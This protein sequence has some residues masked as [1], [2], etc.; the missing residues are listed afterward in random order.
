MDCVTLILEI[1]SIGDSKD[2][3]KNKVRIFDFENNSTPFSIVTINDDFDS[4]YQKYLDLIGGVA[5][6]SIQ[7][8]GEPRQIM[9]EFGQQ[10][11]HTFFPHEIHTFYDNRRRSSEDEKKYLRLIIDTEDHKLMDLPWELLYDTL[12]DRHLC[13]SE[14]S[15]LVRYIPTNFS[16]PQMPDGPL[17]ILCMAANPDG[18][19]DLD[20]EKQ[21]FDEIEKNDRNIEV[22]WVN[23]QTLNNLKATIQGDNSW[24]IFHFIG[25][26]MFDGKSSEGTIILSNDKGR[27][28]HIGADTL[29]SLLKDHKVQL[30]FLNSCDGAQ[31][32]DRSSSM[33]IELIKQGFPSILAMRH[34]ITNDAAITFATTFYSQLAQEK[35]VDIA[36]TRARQSISKSSRSFI[37][38]TT[39]VLYTRSKEPILFKL[40]HKNDTPP[41]NYK[42]PPTPGHRNRFV[43]PTIIL[44]ILVIL[45]T[46]IGIMKYIISPSTSCGPIIT[47]G[48]SNNYIGIKTIDSEPIGIS[49]GSTAFDIAS[50]RKNV[51]DK[52]KATAAQATGD[53]A[54]ASPLWQ[55]AA[56]K[57]PSDAEAQI[58]VENNKVTSSGHPYLTFVVGL[59]F[60]VG[61]LGGTRDILQGAFLLQHKHNKDHLNGLQIRLLIAN[62]GSKDTNAT[63]VANQIVEA[64]KVDKTIVAVLGWPLSSHSINARAVLASAKIP[65]VSPTASSDQLS[66]T[67]YFLRIIPPDSEQ[68]KSA[69]QYIQKT[70]KKKMVAVFYD[71]GDSYSDTLK[72]FLSGN[73]TTVYQTYAI[74]QPENLPSLLHDLLR[75]HPNID[76]IYFAGYANGVI[77]LLNALPKSGPFANLP[78]MGGDALAV[79]SDYPD[80]KNLPGK[81]QL[82]FTSFAFYKQLDSK[83]EQPFLSDYMHTFDPNND[84]PNTI[85]FSLPDGDT[86]LGYDAMQIL[87]IGGE[88]L[89]IKGHLS[90]D[91]VTLWSDLTSIN[92]NGLSGP[93]SFGLDHNPIKKPI[94]VLCVNA[95]GSVQS[96]TCH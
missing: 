84:H 11:F 26:G 10:L 33:A 48:S 83:L 2:N 63:I 82:S 30:I 3:N 42:D 8:A 18:D 40:Q 46:L 74:D 6:R 91:T 12:K 1:V 21:I 67:A 73:F 38:W 43:I 66:D 58:Y 71:G 72:K 19:L 69:A 13:L 29:A 53:Q 89:F 15:T 94:L 85:G 75:K 28:D 88:K 78:I 81:R 57:D 96:N 87:L 77:Q 61:Y 16:A 25:H 92:T 9:K 70:L 65:M 39:P 52:C 51:D 80:P 4:H 55:E 59:T 86:I 7:I 60:Q 14:D 34:K 64:H 22:T 24:H 47:P 41:S 20:H 49:D 68:V 79:I 56:D 76:M 27:K 36:V 50:D 35:L 31:R 44:V 95:V 54:K 45:A 93:I 17:R 23:G 32:I 62:S 5:L 90:Y 37:E